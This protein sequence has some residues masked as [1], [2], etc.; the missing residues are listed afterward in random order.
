LGTA[1]LGGSAND[2]A[3]GIGENTNTLG[4]V[5]GQADVTNFADLMFADISPSA[6]G[7]VE[8]TSVAD[9]SFTVVV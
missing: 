9:L 1:V 6:G 4:D 5:F 8:I 7:D 3:L 2:I